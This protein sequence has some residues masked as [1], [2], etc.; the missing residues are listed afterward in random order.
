MNDEQ[1]KALTDNEVA[2]LFMF[3]KESATFHI[4][5][6]H[7]ESVTFHLSV[8]VEFDTPLSELHYQAYRE[9]TIKA[10]KFYQKKIDRGIR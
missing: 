9:H 6:V 8:D 1:M 5:V 10:K 3:H 2:D 7:K 4:S